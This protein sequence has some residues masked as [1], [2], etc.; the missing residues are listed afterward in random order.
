MHRENPTLPWGP[1]GGTSGFLQEKFSEVTLLYILVEHK[2]DHG[3]PIPRGSTL[4]AQTPWPP[5][6]RDRELSPTN[7]MA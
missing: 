2:G 5:M 6:D 3:S 4:A 1:L 7:T